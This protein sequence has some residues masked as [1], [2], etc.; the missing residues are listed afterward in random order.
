MVF[1]TGV[2]IH[3]LNDAIISNRGLTGKGNFNDYTSS[4]FL[5]KADDLV[6]Y[7]SRHFVQIAIGVIFMLWFAAITG[8]AVR[9]LHASNPPKCFVPNDPYLL[10]TVLAFLFLLAIICFV[11]IC[12]TRLF[13]QKNNNGNGNTYDD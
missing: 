4:M 1:A 11:A 13:S 3:Q 7:N 2:V 8:S 10:G 5:L 6:K 12:Q 9:V